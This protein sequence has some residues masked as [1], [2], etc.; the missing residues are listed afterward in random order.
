M[1]LRSAPSVGVVRPR[2]DLRLI[3]LE[4][5]S[6][7]SDDTESSWSLWLSDDG[8]DDTFVLGSLYFRGPLGFGQARAIGW[9]GGRSLSNEP[10]RDAFLL[11]LREFLT[12]PL[13]DVARRAMT[14]QAALM[15]FTLDVPGKAPEV[16]FEFVK[17][18]AT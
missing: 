6:E 4:V 16:E 5:G 8:E 2:I 12:E 11:W 1:A 14:S 18:P 17:P 3:R 15:D 7:P 9:V 13:Y 10:S